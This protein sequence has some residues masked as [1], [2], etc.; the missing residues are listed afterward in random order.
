MISRYSVKEIEKIF[1]LENR[2]ETFLK[3][4]LSVLKAYANLGIVPVSDYEKVKNLA[5]V[6]LNRINQLEEETK[7]DV[8][9]FTR[10]LSE[11][12]GEEKKWVHYNL[13]ST[14]VVDTSLSLN[15]KESNSIILDVTLSF[16][17]K[18]DKSAIL[19][20]L[21]VPFINLQ[22]LLLTG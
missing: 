14:D 21:Y 12:L 5:K 4:E 8:I 16:I 20:L 15:I 22:A 10:S 6:D 1:S 18:S 9:A 3:V 17:L 7:H 13:T 19:A 2:Y 11:M